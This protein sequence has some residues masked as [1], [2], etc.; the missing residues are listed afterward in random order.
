[1]YGYNSATGL[2]RAAA[3]AIKRGG[4]LR[5]CGD[6]VALRERLRGLSALGERTEE[7]FGR[8]RLDLDIHEVN[9]PV[10]GEIVSASKS[11]PD[12]C[13]EVVL[14]AVKAFRAAFPKNLTDREAPSVSQWQALRDRV[15]AGE[16]IEQMLT[17]L[18][19]NTARLSGKQWSGHAQDLRT[20]VLAQPTEEDRVYFLDQLV[21][22]LVVELRSQAK[23]RRA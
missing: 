16:D 4:V 14:M 3:L 23:E 20:A 5:L 9:G 6:V 19:E 8:F 13:R 17:T 11:P 18:I 7:G 21:R 15:K 22:R 10:K 1:V 2:P 12:N